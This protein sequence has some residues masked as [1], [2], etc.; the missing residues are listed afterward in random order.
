MKL[1]G[2]PRLTCLFVF[3]VVNTRAL[4]KFKALYEVHWGIQWWLQSTSCIH[5]FNDRIWEQNLIQGESEMEYKGEDL[6]WQPDLW[7]LK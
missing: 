2:I 3:Q 6:G 7:H 4:A 5:G 1:C